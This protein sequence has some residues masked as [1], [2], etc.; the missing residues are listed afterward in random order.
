MQ[1]KIITGFFW[2]FYDNLGKSLL[3]NALWFICNIP[4]LF[5]FFAALGSKSPFWIATTLFLVWLSMS[6]TLSGLYYAAYKMVEQKETLLKDYF[7]GLRLF[8]IKGLGYGFLIGLLYIIIGVNINFYLTF[9]GTAKW[10]GSLLAGLSFWAGLFGLL[11]TQYIYPLLVRQNPGFKK[12]I[13]RSFLLTID[14]LGV[15]CIS[16]LT[17]FSLIVLS[18]ITVVGP[19][20]FTFSILTI[21][22]SNLLFEVLAKYEKVDEPPPLK[23]GEKPTSWHQILKKA[24]PQW[25]HENRGWKDLFRPWDV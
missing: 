1:H 18:I 14:N 9:K 19:V 10:T 24:P 4:A 13:K 21:W 3:L 11:V 7:Q 17:L 12:V 2:D 5:F 20:F 22:T 25:R 23:P 8:G 16:G 15:S 6:F